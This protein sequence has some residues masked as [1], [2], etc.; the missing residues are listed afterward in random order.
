VL[1]GLPGGPVSFFDGQPV[2][3]T[4][5][6]DTTTVRLGAEKIFNRAEFVVPLRFGVAWEP[7]GGRDPL[8]RDP[9]DYA[10]VA[11][12]V[13][14]NTNTVKI[15]AAV[16]YR[17]TAFQESQP[18]YIDSHLTDSPDAVGRTASREWRIKV[19]A[20]YRLAD[21]EGLKTFWKRMWGGS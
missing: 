7:Q 17:W 11:F 1:E 15:D 5:T 19:S 13:G 3:T 8:T 18:V 4:A 10:M 2:E 14:V 21:S 12:G 16:Q 6:R 20:I 9:L